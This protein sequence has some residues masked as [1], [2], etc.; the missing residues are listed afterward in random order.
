M[1]T[2]MDIKQLNDQIGLKNHEL[3]ITKDYKQKQEINKQLKILR[4][5]KEIEQIKLKIKQIC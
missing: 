5:K 2:T 1:K 3:Q 4:Y